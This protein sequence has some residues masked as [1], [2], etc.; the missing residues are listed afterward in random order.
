MSLLSLGIAAL[1]PPRTVGG[2]HIST[3]VILIVVVVAV[4]GA[5]A[6]F[7]WRSPDRSPGAETKAER[8][9]IED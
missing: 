8:E 3:T 7:G 2:V 4:L 1:A 9:R 5:L 6:I